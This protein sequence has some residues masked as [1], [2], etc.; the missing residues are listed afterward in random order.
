MRHAYR[1]KEPKGDC[2]KILYLDQNMYGRFLEES[3]SVCG[4]LYQT[5]G[6]NRNRN[7][8]S[9][10][11]EGDPHC[12]YR[13]IIAIKN[14]SPYGDLY[15]V[16]LLSCSDRFAELTDN[17]VIQHKAQ[18]RPHQGHCYCALSHHSS[19]GLGEGS[20][21]DR[22]NRWGTLVLWVHRID[23]WEYIYGEKIDFGVVFAFSCGCIST[24]GQQLSFAPGKGGTAGWGHPLPTTTPSPSAG[25]TNG[26]PWERGDR[27]AQMVNELAGYSQGQKQ[28]EWWIY[29]A[30]L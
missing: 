4:Q 23:L 6:P 30:R 28:K 20:G 18:N 15:L 1:G 8:P 24:H 26:G 2:C 19:S 10:Y 5:Q 22:A 21:K 9:I 25:A 12:N 17:V 16:L 11:R 13:L 14:P 3:Q 7:F 27:G 29:T